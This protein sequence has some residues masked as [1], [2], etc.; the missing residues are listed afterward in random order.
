MV[1]TWVA[2]GAFV[3][4]IVGSTFGW[5]VAH[6]GSPW[7]RSEDDVGQADDHAQGRFS[8]VAGPDKF[9]FRIDTHT[10]VT[11][12]LHA[13]FGVWVRIRTREEVW[14]DEADFVERRFTW[15]Y[16]ESR[17]PSVRSRID[18]HFRSELAS[19]SGD[20][21]TSRNSGKELYS[22]FV[23][24]PFERL[25]A[26]G[27]WRRPTAEKPLTRADADWLIERLSGAIGGSRTGYAPDDLAGVYRVVHY[28]NAGLALGLFEP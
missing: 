19:L 15:P 11:D 5:L 3:G 2:L 21:S 10:G 12:S 24:R 1:L 20:S 8:L 16:T 18:E 17:D 14:T 27:F 13:R 26:K 23:E 28:I 25:T 6:S 7:I 22:E 4:A 9:V